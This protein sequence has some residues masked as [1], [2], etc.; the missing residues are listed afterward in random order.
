MKARLADSRSE[1]RQEE[2]QDAP[3]NFDLMDG[4][5]RRD[6]LLGNSCGT[7]WAEERLRQSKRITTAPIAWRDARGS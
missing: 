4:C 5:S 2:E 6:C 7:H 1:C 3:G